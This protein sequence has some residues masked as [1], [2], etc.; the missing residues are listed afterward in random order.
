MGY[1]MLLRLY[2]LLLA[3]LLAWVV[4][5]A[6]LFPAEWQEVPLRLRVMLTQLPG[7]MWRMLSLWMNA[8]L[9]LRAC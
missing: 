4:L 8:A 7:R 6:P 5:G 3:V 9:P 1:R 2:V